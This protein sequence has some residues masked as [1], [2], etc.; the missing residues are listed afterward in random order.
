[1]MTEDYNDD[2]TPFHVWL[3]IQYEEF[4]RKGLG[5]G[6]GVRNQSDFANHLGISVNSL[7]QYMLGK[8]R[9]SIK[10]AEP[11]AKA[12]GPQIYDRLGYPRSMPKNRNLLWLVDH[13]NEFTGSEQKELIEH[14]KNRRQARQESEADEIENNN[15]QLTV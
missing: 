14:A 13:W 12:L 1:M 8:R 4:V 7:S 15:D 6:K 2:K 10:Q 9:P 11:M 5:Q 3:N